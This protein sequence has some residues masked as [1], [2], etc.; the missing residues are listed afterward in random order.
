MSKT[1]VPLHVKNI[2]RLVLTSEGLDAALVAVSGY[3]AGLALKEEAEWLR[4]TVQDGTP[5][6]GFRR[7][8]ANFLDQR[9]EELWPDGF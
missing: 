6:S 3:F 2:F 5:D 9:A 7:V 1:Q 8:T 4:A